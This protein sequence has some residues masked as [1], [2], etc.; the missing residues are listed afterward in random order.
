[1]NQYCAQSTELVNGR[2]VV[3]GHTFEAPSLEEAES[4]CEEK[5]WEYLGILEELEAELADIS[6]DDVMMIE[7]VM[8]DRKYH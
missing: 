4:I 3:Y 7:F 2:M 5:G 6:D 8:D 1:M